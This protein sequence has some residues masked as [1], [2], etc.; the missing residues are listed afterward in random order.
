MLHNLDPRT[1]FSIEGV[2]WTLA[3]EEQLYLAYFLLL[4]LRNCL[5]WGWTLAICLM[6]RISWFALG[7]FVHRSTGVEIVVYEAALSNWVLSALG[8]LAVEAALGLTRLP[9]WCRDW[10]LGGLCF[11]AAIWLTVAGSLRLAWRGVLP[12]CVSCHAFALGL[13]LLLA[14]SLDDLARDDMD[15]Q[16]C[17]VTYRDL[18]TL[19]HLFLLHLPHARF[20]FD[21][22]DRVSCPTPRNGRAMPGSSSISHCW[23]L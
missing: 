2:F 13:G 19:R 23:F 3:V 21:R 8:A 12:H 14:R 16:E 11:M 5:G 20:H 1:T 18:G 22:T 15:V 9:G 17:S 4:W 6:T 7:F 10:R